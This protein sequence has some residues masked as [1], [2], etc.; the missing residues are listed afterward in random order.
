MYTADRIT[1]YF[2]NPVRSTV[3]EIQRD[4]D[5]L[6][7]QNIVNKLLAGFPTAAVML[8]KHR[9][10]V[11]YNKKAENLLNPS[12]DKTLCGQRMGEAIGCIHAFEMP[13]GCGTSKFCEECGAGKCNKFTRET[14]QGCSEE[15]RITVNTGNIESA[16]D[17]RVHTS[18]LEL[19]KNSYTV[20]AVEDIQNEKR[21]KVLEKIF[22]HDVLN[23]AAAVYG[24]SEIIRDT[25][26]ME[27]VNTFKENLYTSSEQLIKE[28]QYQRDLV[29]AEQGTLTIS[30]DNM[31]I[32]EILT[33]SYNL[34]RN[35][36]LSKDKIFSL[37]P[38]DENFIIKS[39][40]TLLIRCIGNLIKNAFE[41]V[42]KN[43]QVYVYAKR[44]GDE[45]VFYVKNDGVIPEN[46]QLQIFQRSFSTKAASGRGIGTYSVKLLVEQYLNGKVSFISNENLGTIFSIRIP[47]DS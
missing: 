20:F 32:N 24:I 1:S 17:L 25:D 3:D 13:A 22:F 5:F 4:A 29:N 37:K 12:G 39:D 18:I 16:L 45:A 28:I 30:I 23:T 21:R 42:S 6:A 8:D 10:I 15:C 2:D 36:M 43:Q 38:I 35:H 9:Q 14:F 46:I 7:N 40:S 19:D 26:D 47:I 44:E 33:H 41:A 27:E 11:T 31:S 34:Y